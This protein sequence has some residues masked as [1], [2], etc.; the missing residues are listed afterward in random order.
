MTAP[1]HMI[2]PIENPLREW[3][4]PYMTTAVSRKKQSKFSAKLRPRCPTGVA[5]NALQFHLLGN[6]QRVLNLDSEIADGAF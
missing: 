1:D 6:A 4:H 5:T 3:A 2:K